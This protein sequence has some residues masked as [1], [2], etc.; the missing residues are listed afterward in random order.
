M[1]QFKILQ[2]ALEKMFPSLSVFSD[3]NWDD[4]A[5]EYIASHESMPTNVEDFV[6]D[7]P[8]YLQSKAQDGDSPTFL[9]ELAFFELIQSQ[10]LLID[11][12]TPTTPGIYLNSTLSFLNLEF[13]VNLMID[14]ATK[15]NTQLIQRPHILC[16]FKHPD[17]G[18]H[19]VDISTAYLN[20]LQELEDGPLKTRSD[21][22]Q[23]HQK[24]LSE[25]IKLGLI[26]EVTPST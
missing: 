8:G 22:P 13:D 5:R 15:G 9:F 23:A 17:L 4:V 20:V 25:L 26:L 19:H 18:L 12:D 24:T 3:L 11:L 21:L 6:F 16:L 10:L 2:D 14:E 1:N 7:F